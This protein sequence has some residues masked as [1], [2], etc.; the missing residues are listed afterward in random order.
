MGLVARCGPLYRSSYRRKAFKYHLISPNT[1]SHCLPCRV[2]DDALS[3][4]RL[5]A[6]DLCTSAPVAVQ[7]LVTTL[8]W[9][10]TWEILLKSITVTQFRERG[11]SG[12][13]AAYL[14]EAT[15]QSVC[16]PTRWERTMFFTFLSFFSQGFKGG[17]Y[18]PTG[19][20][21]TNL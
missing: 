1:P 5:I 18:C 7:T 11:S 8:R 4:A 17:G 3:I 2:A 13:E 14:R 6:A 15:A 20:E 19:A 16:Y 12:L 21:K 9:Y 10:S